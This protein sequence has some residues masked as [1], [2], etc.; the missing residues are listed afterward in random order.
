MISFP[1]AKINLGLWVTEKRADGYHSLESVFYPIRWTDAVELVPSDQTSLEISGLEVPGS[2]ESN[3]MYRAWQKMDDLFKI[4][5]VAMYLHK[6]VPMG[7]GLGGG[8]ANAAAIINLIDSQFALGLIAEERRSIA[9]GLGSD[10]AFF[11]E[12]IPCFASGKGELLNPIALNL[13]AYSLVVIHPGII[14]N[15][16]EAY[17]NIKPQPAKYNL[18]SLPD[19]SPEYWKGV[20]GNDFEEGIF[21][22]YPEVKELK[23]NLYK[24]GALYAAMS[25]S[26]SAVFGLFKKTPAIELLQLPSHY[27]WFIQKEEG[28]D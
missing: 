12:S 15:T 6:V 18:A 24:N 23:E 5:P 19:L 20:V 10:C 7:A 3:L 4:G 28:S 17:Q 26:G 14:S 25:G 9:S 11:I 1:G 22:K 2:I 16:A 8:S 21:R 27:S 13:N